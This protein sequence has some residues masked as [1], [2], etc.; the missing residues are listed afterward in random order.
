MLSQSDLGTSNKVLDGPLQPVVALAMVH[1]GHRG[2]LKF[3]LFNA[4]DVPVK[5]LCFFIESVAPASRVSAQD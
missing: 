2:E 4:L 3:P 1:L 5:L